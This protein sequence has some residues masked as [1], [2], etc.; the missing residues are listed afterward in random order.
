M[1]VSLFG[2]T[3]SIPFWVAQW[4]ENGRMRSRVLGRNSQLPRGVAESQLAGILRPITD[5]L[6]AIPKV[7]QSLGSYVE[8]TFLP[9][10]RR[11]WKASTAGTSE[12]IIRTHILPTL[13]PCRSGTSIANAWRLTSTPSQHAF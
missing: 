4:S 5:G 2:N 1:A 10:K 9:H 13:G 7:H 3:A 8:G 12:Q 6:R 11:S